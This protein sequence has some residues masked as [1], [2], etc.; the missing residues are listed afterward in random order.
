MKLKCAKRYPAPGQA[1]GPVWAYWV[2][3]E[4][5]SKVFPAIG[6]SSAM[7]CNRFMTAQRRLDQRL[8][9]Y[10]QNLADDREAI[11]VAEIIRY[12]LEL[13]STNPTHPLVLGVETACED[14]KGQHKQLELD[15]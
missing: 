7:E 1:P 13:R 12:A 9:E 6:Y 4:D 10:M 14:M 3:A 11:I 2:A 15:L 8:A 5:G